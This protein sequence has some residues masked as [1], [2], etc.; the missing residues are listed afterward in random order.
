MLKSVVV[1]SVI[2]LAVTDCWLCLM[3]QLLLYCVC[4]VQFAWSPRHVALISM[5]G[6]CVCACV[7]ACVWWFTHPPSL[8]Q[9]KTSTCAEICQLSHTIGSKWFHSPKVVRFMCIHVCTSIHCPCLCPVHV[10]RLFAQGM[11]CVHGQC[12]VG[13]LCA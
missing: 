4:F 1:L 13:V 3:G 12:V 10:G 11:Y 2:L 8:Y 5:D 9:L 7:C 6:K